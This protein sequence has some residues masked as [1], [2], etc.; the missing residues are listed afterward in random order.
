MRNEKGQ[1]EKGLIP[2]NKETKGIMKSNKT[3]FKK[4][5]HPSLK[6]EFKKGEM[7]E[8]M[9]GKKNHRWKGGKSKCIDCGK[10]VSHYKEIRCKK[11]YSKFN[12]KENNSNWKGGITPENQKIRHSI[13]YD[14]WKNSV[15]ARDN[16]VCQKTKIR[17]GV[18]HSHHI[19]NFAQFP[20]LRFAIDN[21]I[22]FSK[23]I[24]KLFHKIYGKKN[25]TKEQLEEFLKKEI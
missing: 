13:E 9:K 8:K 11:C 15:F 24:H 14:L 17:G 16:W 21:G 22:T 10:Q 3:S 19:Q 7:S 25:N 12:Q 1:F 5:E 4:G 20:E 23:Q 2:W 18:L 6:T